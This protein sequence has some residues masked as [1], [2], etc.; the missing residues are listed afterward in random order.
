MGLSNRAQSRCALSGWSVT[1]TNRRGRATPARRANSELE[2]GC[3][4]SLG[5][6]VPPLSVRELRCELAYLEVQQLDL[7]LV[8]WL[9]T[10]TGPVTSYTWASPGE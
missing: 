9:I 5:L 6:G 10:H 8:F 1:A 4:A 3:L 7:L 2:L